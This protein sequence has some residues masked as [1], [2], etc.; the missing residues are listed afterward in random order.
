MRNSLPSEAQTTWRKAFNSAVGQGKAEDDAARIAWGAVKQSW[1]KNEQGEWVKKIAFITKS[2]E[3][4]YTLG[5]VYEPN[6]PDAEDDFATADEIE[7]A[8]WEFSKLLQGKTPV[9]KAGIRLIEAVAKAVTTGKSVQIDVT[10]L[11]EKL[12]KGALGLMHELWS[13]DIGTIVE[14]Y[15]A[16]VDMVIDSE[17]VTKGTWLMGIV[18]SPE[19]FEKVKKGEI[20]GLSMGGTAIRI[21]VE[22]GVASAE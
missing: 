22:G 10:E 2:E 5:V 14:N 7:K 19:A 8:C 18:W 17:K 4:R 13:D 16:P 15:I 9:A 12:E 21:P 11:V 20:T 3:R 6:K 1:K